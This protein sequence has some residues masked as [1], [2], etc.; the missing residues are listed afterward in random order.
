MDEHGN[1]CLSDFG[2]AKMI[3]KNERSMTFCGT[4]DYLAPEVIQGNGSD[5]MSDWWSLG[6]ITYEM[7]FGLPPF[8]DKND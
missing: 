4:P 2:L 7:L 3:R 8:Y 1:I 5:K 6:V